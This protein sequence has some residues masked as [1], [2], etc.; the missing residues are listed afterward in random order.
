MNQI[1]SIGPIQSGGSIEKAP[2][3]KQKSGASFKETFQNFCGGCNAMQKKAD[4][5]YRR[6]LLER[7]QMFIR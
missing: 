3:A 7:L 2:G 6:W 5:R 1:N 4:H